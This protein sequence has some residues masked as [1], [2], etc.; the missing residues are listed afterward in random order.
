MVNSH[1]DLLPYSGIIFMK[2][3]D[4]EKISEYGLTCIN[5]PFKVIEDYIQ[6][7]NFDTIA[8]YVEDYLKNQHEKSKHYV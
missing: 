4:F 7:N 8:N 3:L 6:T 5:M 1:P 2:D